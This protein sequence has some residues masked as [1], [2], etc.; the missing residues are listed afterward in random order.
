[1]VLSDA[2]QRVAARKGPKLC[3]DAHAERSVRQALREWNPETEITVLVGPE[4]GLS[5]SELGLAQQA[6]FTPSS[7]GPF[8]LRSETA[9]TVILGL[10]LAWLDASH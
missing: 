1:M 6:G 9:A 10:L 2:L 3:L 7:L 5:E 8:V 4:G